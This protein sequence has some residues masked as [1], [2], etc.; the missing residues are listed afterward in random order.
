MALFLGCNSI[1]NIGLNLYFQIAP[2]KVADNQN[3]EKHMK[4]TRQTSQSPS[5][6]TVT[7]AKYILVDIQL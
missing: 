6:S 2:L 7:A 5:G 1:W 4:N 3:T